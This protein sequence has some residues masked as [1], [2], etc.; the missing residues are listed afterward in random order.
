LRI[1]YKEYPVGHGVAPQNF[2]D[3]KNWLD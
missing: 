1:M 3:F 2:W